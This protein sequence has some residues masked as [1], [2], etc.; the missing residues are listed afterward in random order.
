MSIIAKQYLIK[1]LSYELGDVLTANDLKTVQDHLNDMLSMYEV[2][3]LEE[4]KLDGELEDLL[5]AFIDAKEIEGRS[6]KTIAHYQYRINRMMHEINVPIRQI[7]VF[8]LRRYLMDSKDRGM[9]DKTIEGVRSVMCSFFGWLFKEGLLPAN[10]CANLAPIKCQKKVRKPY[11]SVD[12][13]RL[14]ECCASDRDRAFI[15]FALA[16]GCRISEI[17]ALNRNSIDFQNRECKVLGKGNKERVVFIDDVTAMLVKR[18]L[19]SRTDDSVALFAGKGTDRMTPGGV[20]ARLHKIADV[21]GVDNVHPHRFRRTLATSLICH[22]MQIQEVAAIL[23]HDKLDTTMKY[24]YMD[25][26]NVRNSYRKY[27]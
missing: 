15:A 26:D 23:G 16:T 19:D 13:E 6:E 7:T 17:C 14:K 2:E 4:G 1:Q 3:G 5:R 12:I 18:Y 8:H 24:V 11:S 20:R 21:A 22:G 9:T 27:A 10:P 25:K